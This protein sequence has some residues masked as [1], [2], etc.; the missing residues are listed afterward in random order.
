MDKNIKGDE[1]NDYNLLI[2]IIRPMEE[3]FSDSENM[4]K[5]EAWKKEKNKG[6]KD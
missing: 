3:F 2:N 5:F 1:W 4:R 6:L